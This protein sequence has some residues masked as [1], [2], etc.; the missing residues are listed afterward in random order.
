MVLRCIFVYACSYLLHTILSDLRVDRP[1]EAQVQSE[2]IK[3]LCKQQHVE[4]VETSAK[5]GSGVEQCLFAAVSI[6]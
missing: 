5:T 1:T 2:L 6:L 3:D 4:Y